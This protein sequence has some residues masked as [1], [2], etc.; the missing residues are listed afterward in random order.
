MF[1]I[2]I[3]TVKGKK[4][5]LNV[6]SGGYTLT[7]DRAS[8]MTFHNFYSARHIVYTVP[9]LLGFRVETN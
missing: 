3:P 7:E 5:L 4:Y 2:T 1:L 9:G 8:A 6:D